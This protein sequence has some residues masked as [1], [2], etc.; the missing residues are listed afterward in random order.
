VERCFSLPVVVQR[1]VE[2]YQSLLEKQQVTLS[3]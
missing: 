3:S 2:L 1:H